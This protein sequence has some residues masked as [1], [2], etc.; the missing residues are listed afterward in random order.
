MIKYLRING[1]MV[2]S[3]I[4]NTKRKQKYSVNS[5]LAQKLSKMFSEVE[6]KILSG[7]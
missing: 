3:S 2:L 4:S 1:G 5:N 6:I 7:V